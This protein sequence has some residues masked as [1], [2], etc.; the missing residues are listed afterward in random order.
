M[1]SECSD[2]DTRSPTGS[3]AGT[4]LALVILTGAAVAVHG[5]ALADGLFLD[6]HW[7]RLRLQENDWSFSA[8]LETATIQPDRFIQTWWQEKPVSWHYLRPV[9]VLVAKA[10]YHLSDGSV[11]AWHAISLVVH[12]LSTLLIY[13][14]A[15]QLTHRRFWALVAGL[16]FV[17]YSHNLYAVA[18]LAAQN[19]VLQT[20]LMLAALMCY[21]RASG[22]DL[23]CG[24]RPAPTA[25]AVTS[26]PK[27]SHAE[28]QRP[29]RDSRKAPSAVSAPLRGLPSSPANKL[30]RTSS[31]DDR[32]SPVPPIRLGLLACSVGLWG[33]ALFSRENAVVLPVLL[34][35]FD[36]A[37]GGRHHLRARWSV[38]A[39]LFTLAAAFALWRIV[40]F[41]HPMPDFYIRR[42]HGNWPEYLAWCLAKLLHFWT[43]TIWLSPM[44]VG[45]SGRFNPLTEVPGDCL[46]MAAILAILGSYYYF[47]T[48]RVR[49]YWIWPLWILLSLLP[50]VPLLA[51]PHSAYMP[52]VAFAIGMVLPAALRRELPAGRA[53]RWSA[54]VAIWFL[55][56]I[57]SYMPIYRPMWY[58]FLAAERLTIQRILNDPPPPA[59]AELFFINLPFTNVYAQLHL[60]HAWG[61]DPSPSGTRIED[62]LGQLPPSFDPSILT[63]GPHADFRLHALT[64]APDPLYMDCTCRI[65]QLDGHSFSL[66]IEGRPYF[67]STLGRFL[68]EGM[69][70][71][72]PFRTGQEVTTPWY[73][74]T[75]AEADER[76]VWRLVFR[77]REPLA[78]DRHAFYVAT[79][80]CAAARLRFQPP[81]VPPPAPP[82]PALPTPAEVRQAAERL[83]QGHAQAAELLFATAGATDPTLAE[84][85]RAAL[86][87]AGSPVAR[88]LAAPAL[89]VWTD[90]HADPAAWAHARTWW[91][92][93]VED[94]HLQAVHQDADHFAS[95]RWTRGGLFRIREV[96]RLIIRTDAYLTGPPFPGPRKKIGE[97]APMR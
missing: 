85:A 9:A 81:A 79:S 8:L 5:W 22:L 2:I 3:Q 68:V 51:T 41:D 27:E 54:A 19:I 97:S 70:T 17:V 96:A 95:L 71:T 93:H 40:V 26:T 64:Y 28:T 53:A 37:F 74:V 89:E 24:R 77:F 66:A 61:L 67:G 65:E 69:R 1:P 45:P 36:L 14:L 73:T 11:K 52:S 94:R 50:V 62:F 30:L 12:C 44:T 16:L 23:Y 82:P 76:G 59:A 46:L 6:D 13:R 56:A 84:P 39:L 90:A 86:C 43:A 48:R 34:A 38:Y 32:P 88:A 20:F 29:Q 31:A 15:V 87:Q 10:V 92:R 80:E 35:A 18:W 33:L 72:G 75:I 58:S 63:R 60:R 42:P 4:L 55:I 7:H 78:G 91:L 49:G 25:R 21:A 57:T 47:A 83:K